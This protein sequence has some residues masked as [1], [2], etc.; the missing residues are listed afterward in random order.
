[1]FVRA[2]LSYQASSIKDT[3]CVALVKG[4][5]ILLLKAKSSFPGQSSIFDILASTF[6]DTTSRLLE[7]DNVL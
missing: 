5:R 1:M 3:G 7:I 2:T 6:D 4:V